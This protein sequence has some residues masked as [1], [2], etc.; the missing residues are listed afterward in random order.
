MFLMNL[1]LFLFVISLNNLIKLWL[2]QILKD[3]R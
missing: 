2:Q 3:N 1:S